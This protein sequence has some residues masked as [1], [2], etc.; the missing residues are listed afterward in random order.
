MATRAS[1]YLLLSV[2][3]LCLL[4]VSLSMPLHRPRA[5]A[6]LDRDGSPY[7]PQQPSSSSSV[8]RRADLS[9]R[10]ASLGTLAA[11]PIASHLPPGYARRNPDAPRVPSCLS[12]VLLSVQ[13]SDRP[14]RRTQWARLFDPR[15]L[16]LKWGRHLHLCLPFVVP[17]GTV[18]TSQLRRP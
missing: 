12:P 13:H 18:S 1:F 5:A 3:V 8:P 15:S 6:F 14:P 7:A 10:R 17:S 16:H 9:P 11:S 2:L 4:A